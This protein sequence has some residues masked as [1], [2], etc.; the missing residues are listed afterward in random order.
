MDARVGGSPARPAALLIA[1][2]QGLSVSGV[3]AWAVRL[4]NGLVAR[5]RGAGLI[6]HREPEGMARVDLGLD[7]RVSVFDVRDLPALGS[8]DDV[9]AFVPRYRSAVEW[10]WGRWGMGGSPVVLSPNLLGDCYGVAAALTMAV[11]ELVRV[12]GWRHSD[13]EYE[14]RVIGHY[15]GVLGRVVGVSEELAEGTRDQLAWRAGDVS[16]VPY[17][18]ETPDAPPTRESLDRRPLRLAYTGRMEHRQKRVMALLTMSRALRAR[19]VDHRLTVVG[20]GPA[21]EVFDRAAAGMAWVRRAPACGGAEVRAMLDS[22]DAIVLASRYEGLSVSM[23]EGMARGCAAVVTGVRSGVGQAVRDGESGIVVDVPPEADDEET[24]LAMAGAVERLSRWDVR[25]M[26]AAAWRTVREGFSLDRH[27]A[28]AASVID[29]VAAEPARV[30]PATRACAFTSGSAGGVA[31]SGTVPPDGAERMR[32]ALEPLAG[33]TVV[34]HGAGRHTL[35][36]AGV[37]AASP[38]RIVAIADDDPQRHGERLWGW[39]VIAPSAA[40]GTGATDVVISSWIHRG[41]VWARRGVYEAQGLTVHRL[42][43]LPEAEDGSGVGR[44]A[45]GAGGALLG[46]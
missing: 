22:S 16:C 17:G 3:T 9:S 32:R 13:H 26:G 14:A 41:A 42:Y 27:V 31:G 45:V 23:L 18:V 1:L 12:V 20:D 7:P 43:E 46:V 35:E 15:E 5:G 6:V 40:G 28:G 37:L 25:A 30:W 33:R 38:A 4:A 24:G 29:E 10:M 39:P 36:L 34:L 21:A 44:A 2:P 11:P 19:G 8:G